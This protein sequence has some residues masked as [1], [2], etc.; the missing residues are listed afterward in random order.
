MLINKDFIDIIRLSEEI[1]FLLSSRKLLKYSIFHAS[2]QRRFKSC[3]G[4]NSIFTGCH[5]F[6]TG[7]REKITWEAFTISPGNFFTTP[8]NFSTAPRNF[9]IPHKQNFQIL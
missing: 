8:G 3:L 2:Q 9:S 4:T 5:F 6:F 1:P 7:C